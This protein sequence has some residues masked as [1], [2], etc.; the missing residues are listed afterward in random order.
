[1]KNPASERRGVL[2]RAMAISG[3]SPGD[4]VDHVIDRI[5]VFKNQEIHD[6]EHEKGTAQEEPAFSR[7][8]SVVDESFELSV[9]HADIT[10]A[11]ARLARPLYLVAIAAV[12]GLSRAEFVTEAP[13]L[14]VSHLKVW[15]VVFDHILLRQAKVVPALTRECNE[16]LECAG[17]KHKEDDDDG[18]S[19][20]FI[21]GFPHVDLLEPKGAFYVFIDLSEA[22]KLS[23][24]GTK[25]ETAAKVAEILI[26]EFA[27]AVIPC[28]DFGFP[29]HIRLSYAISMESIEKGLNRIEDFLIQL[30]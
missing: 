1:M 24:K 20:Y 7:S 21:K 19:S 28:A 5:P 15:L 16:G 14:Q 9:S 13:N 6:D 11:V 2:C 8:D 3:K 10:F 27:V 23:Y 25:L 17:G 29:T 22:L 30:Q 18:D 26:N 4:V 12:I